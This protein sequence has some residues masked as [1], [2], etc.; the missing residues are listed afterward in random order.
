MKKK[1]KKKDLKEE[2][3]D[4]ESEGRPACF[5]VVLHHSL[6]NPSNDSIELMLNCAFPGNHFL[7]YNH[8]WHT[9]YLMT[10]IISIVFV[11]CWKVWIF[12]C[13]LKSYLFQ[14]F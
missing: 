3:C 8:V 13:I 2:V 10:K 9:F 1:K 5:G 6:L 7:N 4:E 14:L 12:S 11:G